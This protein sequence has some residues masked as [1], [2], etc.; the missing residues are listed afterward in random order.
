MANSHS[1]AL[2]PATLPEVRTLFPFLQ[3]RAMVVGA[4]ERSN[5]PQQIKSILDGYPLGNAVLREFLQN[6]DD[7]KATKQIF[8]IDGRYHPTERVVDP[9][10]NECQGP[11]LLAINDTLFSPSDWEALGTIHGSNKTTDETK[12]GKYG[13]GFRACYHLTDNPHV[14]SGD[15][16]RI[17]DP[18]ER[19]QGPL[20]GGL[21][22]NTIT[23]AVAY[24]DHITAFQAAEAEH[25]EAYNGTAIRLPLRN[26][27][28][29]EKSQIRS[30]A[31]SVNDIRSLFTKF[32]H[33]ELGITLLFLKHIRSVEL[34]E[35]EPSGTVKVIGR[36]EISGMEASLR[37][38]SSAGQRSFRCCT[39]VKILD[40]EPQARDWRIVHHLIERKEACG[41]LS[42]RLG[43]TLSEDTLQKEK[44]I[45]HVGLA[46]PLDSTGIDG[47]LF[48]LL[49]LSIRPGLP[50]CLH[51]TFALT[52]DRQHLKN[53]DDNA[54][55]QHREGLLVQWNRMLFNTLAPD[56]WAKLLQV[57]VEED[58]YPFFWRALPPSISGAPT[59]WS[60][61]LP[62]LLK[63]IVN[64]RLRVF[65]V[66]SYEQS[67]S[68]PSYVSFQEAIFYHPRPKDIPVKL[69]VHI[70]LPVVQPP[71]GRP[72]IL[73][74]QVGYM[75]LSPI[76]AS[77]ALKSRIGRLSECSDFEK[78]T[79]LDFILSDTSDSARLKNIIGLP[80]LPLVNGGWVS[81][82]DPHPNLSLGTKTLIIP[83]TLIEEKLFGQFESSMVA[84]SALPPS[85]QSLFIN[86][87]SNP[88]L[89]LR[90]RNAGDVLSYLAQAVSSWG[91]TDVQVD[92]V[93]DG[94]IDWLV[95]FWN[96]V[97]LPKGVNM[98]QL[99][100]LH[101]IPTGSNSVRTIQG[102]VLSLRNVDDGA[103]RAFV[104]LGVHFLHGSISSSNRRLANYCCTELPF[105]LSLVN[106]NKLNDLTF[107]DWGALSDY[108]T[109][110]ISSTPRQIILAPPQLQIFKSLKI[111]PIWT[112]EQLDSVTGD[113]H[114]I[115]Q[116][117][118]FPVPVLRPPCTFVFSSHNPALCR[119]LVPLESMKAKAEPAVLQLAI[120][121]WTEQ[122]IG[123]Q[124]AYIDRIIARFSDLSVSHR[125]KFVT[126]PFV[127][128]GDRCLPPSEVIDPS[129]PLHHLYLDE[130]LTPT[131]A[132][133]AGTEKI[134]FLQ[135]RG[136]LASS[137]TRS[138]VA[139]RI[140]YISKRGSTVETHRKVTLLLQ[141]LDQSWDSSFAD[142]IGGKRA[143]LWLPRSSGLDPLTSP[144]QCRDTV[145]ND[146]C[147][148]DLCLDTLPF[149]LKNTQLR[150]ALGWDTELP[151]HIVLSQLTKTLGPVPDSEAQKLERLKVIIRELS[152][153]FNRNSLSSTELERLHGI[154][155]G[156]EW[157][158][159]RLG[160]LLDV[161]HAMLTANFI[162][163]S[164]QQ[165]HHSLS[166][167]VNFLKKMGCED[168]PTLETLLNEYR[169]YTTTNM[170][171][172]DSE[173]IARILEE[174]S[175][176]DLSTSTANLLLPGRDGFWWPYERIYYDDLHSQ[177][178]TSH[179]VI[180][181]PVH[182][183][184]SATLSK[185]LKIP[186]LSAL[187]L[188]EDD[189]DEDEDEDD[190]G[191]AEALNDRI[192][193][194]LKDYDIKHAFNEFVANASDAGAT[195][196]AILLDERQN[197]P[198]KTIISPEFKQFQQGPA[199]FLFNN[200][201][202]KTEDFEGI[203]RIGRGSKKDRAHSIGKY[204]LGALSLFHFT[205]LPMVISNKHIMILDPSGQYLPSRK[206]SKRTVL[207]RK[208]STFSSRYPDQLEPFRGLPNIPTT[209]PIMEFPGT[210][211][212]LPLPI[213]IPSTLPTSR[214][215]H[216]WYGLLQGYQ[217]LG[218]N[219]FFFTQMCGLSAGHIFLQQGKLQIQFWWMG[220]AH[221]RGIGQHAD[222]PVTE[223]TLSLQL[224][225]QQPTTERWTITSSTTPR[226]HTPVQFQPILHDL[227]IRQPDDPI[228][229][230]TA[231]P[232]PS[233]PDLKFYLFSTLRLPRGISLPFH[234]EAPFAIPSSRRHIHFDSRDATGGD[235]LPTKYNTWLLQE[236]LPKH[237]LSSL[238]FLQTIDPSSFWEYWPSSGS[239]N[240][241]NLVS[242]SFYKQ[243]PAS[244]S[245][246]LQ[247][248]SGKWLAPNRARYLL[249]PSCSIRTVLQ[250]LEE[251]NI[252]KP[253]SKIHHAFTNHPSAIT[254]SLFVQALHRHE[255][256]IRNLSKSGTLSFTHIDDTLVYLLNGKVNI[257]SLPLLMT[258]D[259]TL[260]SRSSSEHIYH[261]PSP[262]VTPTS[263]VQV[264]SLRIPNDIPDPHENLRKWISPS[265]VLD[266]RCHTNSVK[267]LLADTNSGVRE[268]SDMDVC[269][270]LQQKL[271]T[272]PATT[273]TVEVTQWIQDFWGVFPFFP[274]KPT[275]DQLADFPI[276]PT[277]RKHHH[278]SLRACRDGRVLPSHP[279]PDLVI[280]DVLSALNI[281]IIQSTVHSSL[282]GFLYKEQ[283]SMIS[284][285]KC[286]NV[287]MGTIPNISN[288][289][290]FD[291]LARW[292]RENIGSDR[293]TQDEVRAVVQRLPIW[294]ASLYNHIS[295]HP[296][297]DI[298]LLPLAIPHNHEIIRCYTQSLL[299]SQA[300]ITRYSDKKPLTTAGVLDLLA[301][302][303]R[304]PHQHLIQYADFLKL[305]SIQSSARDELDLRVPDGH[306]TM[307]PVRELYDASVPLF[308]GVFQGLQEQNKFIHPVIRGQLQP[309]VSSYIRR[310]VNT[311]T[312]IA[313]ARQLIGD[314][315]NLSEEESRRRGELIYNAYVSHLPSQVMTSPTI[316]A[317]FKNLRFIPREASRC[318]H[319]SYDVEIYF[320]QN[321]LPAVVSPSHIVSRRYEHIAW[322]QR[323][324]LRTDPVNLLSVNPQFGVPSASDVVE[325]LRFLA[326]RI[327]PNHPRNQSLIE[328][329]M[330][331]YNWLRENEDDAREFLLAYERDA[332]FLNVDDPR[333]DDWT[334]GWR[335]ARQLMLGVEWDSP[336][337][338]TFHVRRFL[339]HYEVV[340]RAAGVEEM[341]S[342]EYLSTSTSDSQNSL[343]VM[344]ND[345]RL[346]GTLTNV[347]LVPTKADEGVDFHRLRCH[348]SFLA[349]SVSHLREALV[350][351]SEAGTDSYSFTGTFV[352][353]Y[354][355]LEFIYSGSISI[356]KELIVNDETS[357]Y[358]L[359]DELLGLLEPAD[360]WEMDSFKEDIGRKIVVDFK[361]LDLHTY[362]SVRKC[363]ELYRASTLVSACKKFEQKNVT[364]IRRLR[365]GGGN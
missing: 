347:Y 286:L 113:I 365:V 99:K 322:T 45:P 130:G 17:F 135:V 220:H 33:G 169:G 32:V 129:S 184:V 296:L 2:F 13:L 210:L 114:F 344:Y 14:L 154:V 125:S 172:Q 303:R 187:N 115:S 205:D 81:V 55:K 293:S 354:A 143:V 61:L 84:F 121:S 95:Q 18:H 305:L 163:R 289:P 165:V 362:E 185:K 74:G 47:P 188:G 255:K 119:L 324:L 42:P 146:S 63:I 264:S 254:P 26:Q 141:L 311:E 177:A 343:R 321:Q 16:L 93:S 192:K 256:K 24:A 39:I 269:A 59:Y 23:E 295:L 10:L 22:I 38:D 110:M 236:L 228:T 287:A 1:G 336:V 191:M 90:V 270:L 316:W 5:L 346:S 253:H 281:S 252:V 134:R 86:Y 337:H 49:P 181:H 275:W 317:R 340:L 183:S 288:V 234:L 250:L 332:I 127:S 131:G 62:S 342:A 92:R 241:S 170:S 268:L 136:L 310:T 64:Q 142:I 353:A 161:R 257:S 148:F 164:F 231:F 8:I 133:G 363:A 245:I 249:E 111:F 102:Q 206:G 100:K 292:I 240:I 97:D 53:N 112:G 283:F 307:R 98:E 104:K 118:Q 51:G 216:D 175:R 155:N 122:S 83:T 66:L 179:D 333:H 273:H 232:L 329:L 297:G 208:L 348:K 350:N 294:E 243:L 212:R 193:A 89:S 242:E 20:A 226:S 265:R 198:S 34:R 149:Q 244:P 72:P 203:R 309:L 96:N 78:N 304:I 158:P 308:A 315:D 276:V 229:V 79:L 40:N 199:V 221:R 360:Q 224:Y 302:P 319:A 4:R 41:I 21:Y 168:R 278:V 107:K 11:A 12:T 120:D 351:W 85:V 338:G 109:R 70:G 180:V 57:L 94:H 312:V 299:S 167:S 339:K 204:G 361:L 218:R 263:W 171:S 285:L 182:P 194:V 352:G 190:E 197:F 46:I 247:S 284:L 178:V 88:S 222:G 280:P 227:K 44:L 106:T 126:S 215:L 174:L 150:A 201:S 87:S 235:T 331:T 248:L 82:T 237:Y 159:S 328:D 217:D 105:L 271:R 15:R 330:A 251:D 77:K 279:F 56:A 137:L 152:D 71:L 75:Q 290:H 274:N 54:S 202:F 37:C 124:Q 103:T 357:R 153:R 261:I 196:F 35:I 68:P 213:G 298:L 239:D 272:S 132:F 140:Q 230:Q 225:D 300:L 58:R 325:H 211:F 189:E 195:D 30:T 214:S 28:Q 358:N 219:G 27:N 306:Y 52:S 355:F 341:H 166:P 326:L 364:A 176:H 145:I 246:I 313:C 7:A 48:T 258:A 6:S 173:W 157:I 73:K 267:F 327:A 43:Y 60:P 349:A 262:D 259:G 260:R 200:A 238:E 31:F 36:V 25:Q 65:P 123:S 50:L 76:I 277:H 335:S 223:L 207:Y 345:M 139:E 128:V 233:F 3:H 359:L 151:T 117:C 80:L 29:A 69:L 356:P 334:M 282:Q 291:Q 162:G 67:E 147:L 320:D 91:S 318:R 138:R 314:L 209:G 101:L 266:A 9:A 108:L 323:G 19:F 156:R 160:E 301:L 186:F 116:I 144:D